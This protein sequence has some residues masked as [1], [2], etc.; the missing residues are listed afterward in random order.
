MTE[1]TFDVVDIVDSFK[2]IEAAINKGSFSAQELL[3]IMPV[4]EKMQNF[5]LAYQEQ[6]RKEQESK[7]KQETKK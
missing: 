1:L 6:Q 5:L 2:I 3:Q 7:Q 4:Y